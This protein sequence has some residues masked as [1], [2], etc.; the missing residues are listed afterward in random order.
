VIR[1]IGMIAAAVGC[2]LALTPGSALALGTLDQSQ[3]NT[4]G[5]TIDWLAPDSLSQSFTAGLSGR[6]DTVD[7][8]ADGFGA[9]VTFQIQAQGIGALDTQTVTLNG[10]GWTQI[11]L[12]KVV[13]VTKGIPY[14]IEMTPSA[15]HEIGWKGDCADSYAG[16]RAS[17]LEGG[18]WYSIP[19]WATAFFP[20][21][22]SSYCAQ[23]FAFRTYVTP[24]PPP[25]KKPAPAPTA[26]PTPAATPTPTATATSAPSATPSP[27]DTASL[28][29]L[30]ATAVATPGSPPGSPA[31]S[32]SDTI[33][34]ILIAA[35]VVLAL[36]V[37]LLGLL[38]LR[39][40]RA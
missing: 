1:R 10:S 14:A 32:S 16:G 19:G 37:G 13:N 7:V 11:H 12:A 9:A 4:S 23:D 17:V 20:S 3:T 24:P 38:L 35:I 33:V 31:G 39:R 8:N 21:A 15:T 6:L 2:L 18:T 5:T 25:T 36:L 30:G 28:A 27:S 22:L 40:Q 34:P 29:V 26:T